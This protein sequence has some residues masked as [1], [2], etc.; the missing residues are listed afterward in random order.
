LLLLL[1]VRAGAL[2]VAV[3]D[4]VAKINLPD[5]LT[6]ILNDSFLANIAKSVT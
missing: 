3:V 4:N 1:N 5:K 2:V 6:H